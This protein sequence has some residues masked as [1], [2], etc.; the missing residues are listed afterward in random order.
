MSQDHSLGS[1]PLDWITA[2][3]PHA[4]DR[5]AFGPEDGTVSQT[6][7]SPEARPSRQD[8][9]RTLRPKGDVREFKAELSEHLDQ[10]QVADMLEMLANGVRAGEVLLGDGDKAVSMTVGPSMGVEAAAS[11]KKDKTR[12]RIELEWKHRKS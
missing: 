7:N 8:I 9:W 3:Q 2:S 4:G 10:S 11:L 12:L 5:T 6:G 1:D